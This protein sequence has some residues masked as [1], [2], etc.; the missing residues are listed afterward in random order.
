[1]QSTSELLNAIH[2]KS[3]TRQK[4]AKPGIPKKIK[5]TRAEIAPKSLVDK[6]EAP[7]SGVNKNIEINRISPDLRH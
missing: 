2:N 4:D 1:M 5:Q 6:E 7:K 3:R